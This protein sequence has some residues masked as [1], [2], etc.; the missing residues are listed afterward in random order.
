MMA[1]LPE[2]WKSK[3]AK[4]KKSGAGTKR[5]GFGSR[6][7]S[8][9]APL[10]LPN[11]IVG[12][13]AVSLK[14]LNLTVPPPR[15]NFPP[16]RLL[17]PILKYQEGSVE[18]ENQSEVKVTILKRPDAVTVPLLASSKIQFKSTD[19]EGEAGEEQEQLVTIL[20]RPEVLTAEASPSEESSSQNRVLVKS[21]K[22]REEEY[23]EAR[24]RILGCLE[25][26]PVQPAFA[27]AE[28]LE[29]EEVP[30]TSVEPCSASVPE[31]LGD[32]SSQCAVIDQKSI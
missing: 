15:L 27:V 29:V 20:K 26:V 19:D 22:Q 25:E 3:R 32:G 23:A 18:D 31:L 12:D 16:P 17:L 10:Q 21:L 1:Q 11:P 6:L 14:N 7:Q 9:N 5:P 2:E 28:I 4:T 30:S 13:F 24:Q 8:Q